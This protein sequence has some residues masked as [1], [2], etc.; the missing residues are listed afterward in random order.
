M[1][2]MACGGP[3][4][5]DNAEGPGG[6]EQGPP[7]LV[8]TATAEMVDLKR[9]ID[10]LGETTASATVEVKPQVSARLMG[11]H[12]EEG[13]T[14]SEGELLFTLEKAPFE[15]EITQA[16]GEIQALE[17]ELDIAERE[18]GRSEPLVEG[19]LLSTQAFQSLRSKVAQLRGQ[20]EAARGR[21]QSAEVRLDYTEIRA[22]MDS[23]AG[24]H[25]V[26]IGNLVEPGMPGPM[27]TLRTLHPIEVD[28]SV[29]VDRFAEIRTFLREQGSVSVRVSPLN[30]PDTHREARLRA[31]S[32]AVER[33]TGTVDLRAAMPNE[34]Q[35]FWPQEAIR[36][37]VFLDSLPSTVV[38]PRD[39]V[40]LSQA[41]PYIMI[42]SGIAS[43]NTDR[44]P[45]RFGK[46]EQRPVVTG[47]RQ[48]GGKIAI[49]DGLSGGEEVVLEGQIF[50]FPEMRVQIA[51]P[52][53]GPPQGP[54]GRAENQP[55][56]EA[57]T[58]SN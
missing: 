35:L 3:S 53:A 56:E 41:G 8:T 45:A 39:A 21:L 11:I 24:F 49:L 1:L 47:Q 5:E 50:L 54:Q 22:P 37:R 29:P 28:F 14:V 10:A 15:A 36:A 4:P 27:T 30:R 20:I 9:Y 7:R 19:Q 32:T 31:L 44:G 34:D 23:L 6:P 55:A 52:P 2:L 43:E 13:A 57:S 46:V 42:V 48:E 25:Q 51:E 16:R 17:A 33:A 26:D 38:V 58:S 40:Q 18:V 12:F